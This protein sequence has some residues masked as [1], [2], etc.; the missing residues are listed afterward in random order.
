MGEDKD[1]LDT[2]STSNMALTFPSRSYFLAPAEKSMMSPYT[3]GR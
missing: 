3:I 1:Q 2:R